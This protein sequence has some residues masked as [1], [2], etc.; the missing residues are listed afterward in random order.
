MA[1]EDGGHLIGAGKVAR[2]GFLNAL[3]NVLHLPALGGQVAAQC[4]Q[5]DKAFGACRGL[6]Q[7]FQ[8]F[9]QLGRQAHVDGA[10]GGGAATVMAFPL[11]HGECIACNTV[12]SL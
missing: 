8:L 12:H 6:G 3:G 2:V 5:G 1:G 4:L 9:V 11:Q 10:A 7:G